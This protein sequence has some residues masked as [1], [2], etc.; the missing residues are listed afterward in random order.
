MRQEFFYAIDHGDDIRAGLPLNIENDGRIVVGPGSLLGVFHAVDNRSDIRQPHRPAIAVGNDQRAIA[1][2]G[3]ELI[4]RADGVG[5]VR[6]VKRALGH[7]NVGLAER[8]AQILETKTVRSQRGGIRL[9]AHRRTLAATDA[10]KPDTAE[11][12]NFLRER[13]VREVFDFGQRK[14][15]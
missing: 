14:R 2:A 6:A 3:N 4:V 7:V 11:L 8:N 1:V 12:R 9:D 5:L 15:L 10:D 13:G